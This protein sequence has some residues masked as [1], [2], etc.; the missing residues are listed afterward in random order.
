MSVVWKINEQNRTRLSSRIR[1][2]VWNA[3]R[4][5]AEVQAV[6]EPVTKSI[7]RRAS[8]SGP[9]K[10]EEIWG[11][12]KERSLLTIRQVNFVKFSSS[13]CH[14]LPVARSVHLRWLTLYGSFPKVRFK[15]RE[16]QKVS[17]V[18]DSISSRPFRVCTGLFF[19]GLRNRKN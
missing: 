8:L 15:L 5:P 12:L 11:N 9:G 4:R 18:Q 3:S 16:Q 19:S 6:D 14:R 17:R 2:T 1:F 13:S 10:S 7:L